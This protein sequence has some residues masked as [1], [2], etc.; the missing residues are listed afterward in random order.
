LP[1]WLD[2]QSIED[3]TIRIEDIGFDSLVF[4]HWIDFIEAGDTGPWWDDHA[5]GELYGLA[6]KFQIHDIK[7]DLIDLIEN[8][9][10]SGNVLEAVELLIAF[11]PETDVKLSYLLRYFSSEF[12]GNIS[13]YHPAKVEDMVMAVHSPLHCC[14]SGTVGF[15]YERK[16][17]IG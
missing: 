10:F 7:D 8:L 16:R 11:I 9:Q 2:T 12:V 1:P 4:C 6:H 5:W 17:S 15:G 3:G 14:R 13:Y